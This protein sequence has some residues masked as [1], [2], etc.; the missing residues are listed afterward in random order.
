MFILPFYSERTEVKPQSIFRGLLSILLAGALFFFLPADTA[1]REQENL[2]FG[3]LHAHTSISGADASPGEVFSLAVQVP[4][5]DFF[6]VTDHSHSFENA[7]SGSIAADGTAVSPDWGTGKAAAA[8]VTNGEFVGIFGYEMSFR[9]MD[10]LGHISTFGTPGW[11]SRNQK[12]FD[13]LT[14][15]YNALT[16][17]PGSVSQFNHPGP[18]LG[19][20]QNFAHRSD[21][22][23][24]AIALMEIG[25]ANGICGLDTYISALNQGWH[26]APTLG[27]NSWGLWA[28]TPTVRT[29]VLAEDRAGN[30]VKRALSPFP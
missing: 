25:D 3:L 16:Q 26:L 7:N 27:L 1:A 29:A 28:E 22:Y 24:D 5:L 11:Q 8:A 18:E 23:D 4:G 15:Y 30:A 17:V 6:A 20:F 13:N 2:Y 12:G 10:N 9:D 21:A 14:A 19:A